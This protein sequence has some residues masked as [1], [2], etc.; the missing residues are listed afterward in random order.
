MQAGMTL[1]RCSGVDVADGRWIT[2][3]AVSR[4][5][6]YI[7]AVDSRWK[8]IHFEDAKQKTRA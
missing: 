7:L 8:G 5:P 3:E 4:G 1:Q 6:A 2:G